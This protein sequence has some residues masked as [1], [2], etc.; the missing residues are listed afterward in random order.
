VY[1]AYDG[2]QWKTLPTESRDL[3]P[4]DPA[5]PFADLEGRFEAGFTFMPGIPLSTIYTVPQPQWVSRPVDASV[6]V[7]PDNTIDLFA[8][9]ASPNIRPGEIYEVRSSL[10]NVTISQLREAETEYPE[11][12]S[13]RYLQI[14]DSITPRTI[15]LAQQIAEGSETP[16]DIA[17]AVTL[18]I[19]EN[20]EYNDTVP[21]P[22]SDQDI[23]D[24]MLFDLRQG[25]CNYYATA[26]IVML[27][28][29]GVPAR[30]AVGYA[31][32]HRDVESNTYTV[33]QRD[34][35]A[36]PE[37]YFPGIGW[38]EFEPTL[39]QR[40]LRRPVGDP[41][42]ENNSSSGINSGGLSD[43]EREELLGFEPLEDQEAPAQ[44]GGGENFLTWLILAVVGGIIITISTLAWYKTRVTGTTSNFITRS[45]PVN[46]E[47]GLKRIGLK[48]PTLLRRWAYVS[49]LPIQAR[50]Y[51][52]LNRSL[53]RLGSPAKPNNTPAERA[54]LLENL[55]P[56]A[57]DSIDILLQEYQL[58]TYGMVNGRQEEEVQLI[59]KHAARNLRNLTWFAIGQR[60]L[61]KFQEPNRDRKSIV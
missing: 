38:V 20:I 4:D 32:G 16:Y 1:D 58:L 7:N 33:R 61:A 57:G 8:L 50:A 35:H 48:P 5:L 41:S 28:S 52:Q 55:L 39:N 31:Q 24:W 18:W 54:T 9:Q 30:L 40:P 14:P 44:I 34:A 10:T 21:V 56:N 43:R 45:L 23:I 15:E 46:I 3:S 42:G 51:Q 27:R 6:A 37:V 13:E 60:F 29:L 26:E 59:A 19:R 36:W 49:A 53:H 22:P 25:F 2:T 12:V 47:R 11:W 17:E